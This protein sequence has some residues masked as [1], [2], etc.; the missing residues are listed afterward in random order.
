MT[1]RIGVIGSSRRLGKAIEFLAA[2]IGVPLTLASSNRLSG[3][4]YLNLLSEL[5]ESILDFIFNDCDTIVFLSSIKDEQIDELAKESR[6]YKVNVK[7]LQLVANWA[8]KRQKHFVFVS[9]AIVY[10]EIS[11][12]G[13]NEQFE[14]GPNGLS[15]VYAESKRVAESILEDLIQDGLNCTILRPSSIFGGSPTRSGLIEN[16]IHHAIHQAELSLR[17][18]L[19]QEIGFVHVSEV[20]SFILHVS[21]Y[22]CSG[23]FNVSSSEVYSISEI[24]QQ[25]AELSAKPIKIE[26]QRY[27]GV[28]S[29]HRFRLNIDKALSTNWRP[30]Q[31][32]HDYICLE[33]FYAKQSRFASERVIG[34]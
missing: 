1:Q 18:P 34:P 11:A 33:F 15:R 12:L 32:L 31:S 13:I 21:R 22:S 25:I 24:A 17:E 7:S 14:R 28:E 23:T 4:N 10:K 27:L 3:V 8:R 6:T 2:K 19:D 30:K 29:Q 16:L 20:A 26:K 9:G 5:E